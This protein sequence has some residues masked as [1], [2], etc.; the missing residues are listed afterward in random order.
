MA[1]LEAAPSS[2]SAKLNMDRYTAD[3]PEA[4]Q[5]KVEEAW[6]RSISNAKA[7][8]CHQEN[9]V[10]NAE[11]AEGGMGSLWLQQNAV[12][13]QVTKSYTAQTDATQRQIR[14]VNKARQAM[15]TKAFPELTK[16]VQKRDAALGRK[17][18]CQQAYETLKV[19]LAGKQS[20]NVFVI[21]ADVIAAFIFE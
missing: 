16:L 4:K 9:R 10:M 5:E 17:L 18:M 1:R 7:Q 3:R 21:V 19:R 20:R 8:I 15:Q 12:L 14:E 13:E 11:L 2:S 6:R